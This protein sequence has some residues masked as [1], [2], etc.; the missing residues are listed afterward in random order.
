R[1]QKEQIVRVEHV[2]DVR[3]GG[4][5][6]IDLA[7]IN[8]NVA[9][10]VHVEKARGTEAEH[11]LGP[12]HVGASAAATSNGNTRG[13]KGISPSKQDAL[14]GSGHGQPLCDRPKRR[15]GRSTTV[16]VRS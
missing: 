11:G 13:G 10:T 1:V 8:R 15:R 14:S 16:I 9:P 7:V 5:H 12:S 3:A 4:E 2:V 6:S